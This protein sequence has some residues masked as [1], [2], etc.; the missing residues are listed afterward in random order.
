M[1]LKLTRKELY[2]LRNCVESYRVGTW[3]DS[4]TQELAEMLKKLN[5]SITWTDKAEVTA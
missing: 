1:E 5:H 3:G 2:L 4:K